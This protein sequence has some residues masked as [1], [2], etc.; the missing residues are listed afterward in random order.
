MGLATFLLGTVALAA[1][2]SVPPKTGGAPVRL[3]VELT[4]KAASAGQAPGAEDAAVDL[5]LS[6]GRV[7]DA[8]AWPP[9]PPKVGPEKQGRGWKLGVGPSGRV[10]ARVEAP[11]AA[12][13]TFRSGGK[14]VRVPLQAVL[15]D[16][17][18]PVTQ[19]NLEVTVERLGWD[20]LEV[21]L[22][23]GDGTALPG[24][25]LPVAV[26]Y[27][28]LTPE[29]TEVSLRTTAELRPIEGG[30][31]VWRLERRE[32]VRTNVVG[33]PRKT[34][35]VAMP[36]TEG[37]Y[38]L[39]L[40]STW[41]PLAGLEGS[42]LG[43]W[44]RR[45]WN[46]T[47]T[48]SI[49]RLA[50]SVVGNKPI[51][52][53][54][55]AGAAGEEVME[56]IDFARLR[57]QRP[58]ASGRAP[59]LSQ[60]GTRWSVPEAALV[61]ATRR[62]RLRGWIT[63]AGSETAV[64]APADAAGLAW[65]AL[66]L[67][68][69]NPGRPHRLSV[70]VV[71]GQPSALGVALVDS[72]GPAGRPRVLLDACASGPPI[73]EG[74][75]ASSFS[76]LVWPD[77]PDPV[78][79]LVNRDTLAPVHL[80]TVVLAEL[81]EVPGAPSIVEPKAE[82]R[83]LGLYLATPD[84][85]DRFGGV[86]TSPADPLALAKNVTRYLT[87]CGASSLVV[88]EGLADRARRRA[89]DGQAFQDS[90]GPDRLDLLCRI[91]GRQKYSWWLE[92]A[93]DGPLPGLPGPETDRAKERGLIRV[94]RRG[95][96][97]GVA[98]HPFHPEVRDALVRRVSE[99]SASRKGREGFAGVIIRLGSGPTL[100][101]GPDTGF[102]DVTFARFVREAFAPET[103]ANIPGVGTTE[104]N[105]M[106]ARLQF[107]AGPGRMPW[108]TWRSRAI[109]ALYGTLAEA[110]R[111]AAPGTS[112]AVVTPG[113]DAGPAGH[114]ARRVDLAG[115]APA[116]AWRAVGLDLEAWPGGD[117]APVVFRG[118][119]L[120]PDALVH[121]LATS[122]ELD[123]Q[124]VARP[125]RGLLI[126]TAEPGR[127]APH[128]RAA[129]RGT[130]S[131]SGSGL[132][133]EASPLPEGAASDELM[134]H[135]V[136]ALDAHW[137]ML[138]SSSVAGHEERVRRF[139]RVFRALPGPAKVSSPV[140]RQPFGV[141]VRTLRSGTSSYVSLAN[142]TP[143]PIRLETILGSTES[144]PIDDLG[145]GLRLAPETVAGG[146]SRLVLD[147]LP[148]GVA[149]I[150]VGSPK[151]QV[152]AVT[153]YPSDAVLAGMQA[154]YEELST[155]L[156]KLNQD[157]GGG[158]GPANP[159][160][161]PTTSPLVQLAVARGST[162]LNGWQ[163][164]GGMGH[165]IELDPVRPHSG[166]GSLKLNTPT[167]PASI[168]SES[169]VAKAHPTLTV[170]AWFRSAIPG[171]KVRTWIEA[172]AAGQPYLR[173]SEFAVPAEWAPM[174]IRVGEI[175]AAGLE[176]A[177]LR[178]ELLGPGT[179]WVDDVAVSGPTLTEPERLN[180]RRVLVAA[181]H[182]YREKRFADFARLASSHWAK[183]PG[184]ATLGLEDEAEDAIRTGK[185]T[186]LPPNRLLR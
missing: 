166:R 159:G 97:D 115:L 64:L 37:T 180:S 165:T 62:D 161:E 104:P 128:V 94:D 138:A 176:G 85:L 126:D 132:Y 84:L 127:L 134:G 67:R 92:L 162:A 112:L 9:S 155:Q 75:P 131:S 31:P 14:L 78:L 168:I 124:V 42:R 40:H 119:G 21:D 46:P 71:G 47:A 60:G 175:P 108:L 12:V 154:R 91:L 136:A 123:A 24:E 1:P 80:G 56:T 11:L 158:L 185:A 73:L 110:A 4:W 184:S 25:M 36:R 183:P 139:A 16:L 122:P 143:Y 81:D 117:D 172:E 99:T 57:G 173:L 93:L 43:R 39:E 157:P 66:G 174:T 65:S 103:K 164:A 144:A 182:A 178:F 181:L 19:G 142:D 100:L 135:A 86:E 32:V 23:R 106:S 58:S 72:G 133:L 179:L 146:G 45:R 156:S 49:R 130:R 59:L 2:P 63:H 141:A 28:V 114:E 29:P 152:G 27:N 68:V 98:Y 145:R 150:R 69:P 79:V 52:A 116:H 90:T 160:F 61:E 13:M 109:G 89:L 102:D 125:R 74:G 83:S 151:V 20:A 111:R 17:S 148:F 77:S 101:G 105:R 33:A 147:L 35:D 18:R 5:E 170:Q 171:A 34:W 95:L 120:S 51:A 48:S 10:R 6:E 70:S 153:P 137:V 22:E 149:A 15:D 88:G 38:V 30:E 186:A 44:L 82:A 167:G 41:E 50:L 121:D 118:A 113:L 8:I 3:T 96:P 26:G 107:L 140:D 129:T 177:R 55:G 54:S 76:W 163:A 87:Y 7:L 169:F 53:E